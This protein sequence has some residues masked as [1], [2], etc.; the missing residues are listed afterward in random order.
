[1][2]IHA[3]EQTKYVQLC[4]PDP[5]CVTALLKPAS[6]SGRRCPASYCLSQGPQPSSPRPHHIPATSFALLLELSRL[7]PGAGPL[8][9]RFSRT[10]KL[11]APLPPTHLSRLSLNVASWER[12]PGHPQLVSFYRMS[13]YP[14]RW[15]FINSLNYL[16]NFVVFN[17][18]K[19]HKRSQCPS[20]NGDKLS[21]N[22]RKPSGT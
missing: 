5:A 11:L 18:E 1:M 15:S 7:I 4:L 16:I 3:R 21:E 22:L 14:E 2:G 6:G 19:L 8:H 10:R 12:V 9:L 13:R 17:P 20:H